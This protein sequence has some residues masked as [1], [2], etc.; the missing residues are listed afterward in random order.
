M[1][2][3]FLHNDN[4]GKY[5]PE[6][7]PCDYSKLSK[8]LIEV[9]KKFEPKFAI[10][11]KAFYNNLIYYFCDNPKCEWDL[12]KGLLFHGK[13]GLGKSLSLKIIKKLYFY[14]THHG[15]LQPKK[16][17]DFYGME[18]VGRGKDEL[19]IFYKKCEKSLFVDEVMRETADDSKVVNNWGT[20]E[21]PFS[22][23]MHQM[24]RNF[25]DKGTL[26]H[27]TTNYWELSSYPDG[28][29]FAKTYG[30]EIHDRL[31]EMCNIIHFKGESKR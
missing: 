8:L 14:R 17:F 27:F 13:K 31:K 7:V 24:Y 30:S 22:T 26:Y 25:C 9:G 19:E 28:A 4:F 1:N 20:K 23:A 5:T 15:F 10:D 29:M 16:S 6:Q 18:S 12:S 11:D 21:K 2:L 3:D